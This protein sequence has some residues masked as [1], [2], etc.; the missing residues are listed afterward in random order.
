MSQPKLFTTAEPVAAALDTIVRKGLALSVL[1][2]G[3]FFEKFPIEE[4]IVNVPRDM[5]D[6]LL[7][8]SGVIGPSP[9]LLKLITSDVAT[10]MLMVAID[11]NLQE[12]RVSPNTMLPADWIGRQDHSR[13]WSFLAEPLKRAIASEET[14]RDKPFLLSILE[15]LHKQEIVTSVKILE[16]LGMESL[17]NHLPQ[18]RTNEVG[19]AVLNSIAAKREIAGKEE[20]FARLLKLEVLV[21]YLPLK[22]IWNKVIIPLF[23]VPNGWELPPN[24]IADSTETSAESPPIEA[25]PASGEQRG[26]LHNEISRPEVDRVTPIGTRI[27]SIEASGAAVEGP[28]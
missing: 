21:N 11:Q 17:A 8:K 9:E 1:D 26:E 25:A 3:E 13:L 23:A 22:I 28:K 2:G 5:L 4:Q 27:M 12:L 19:M 7:S 16:A 15:T 10:K 20:T 24:T 18:E 14:P 6:I